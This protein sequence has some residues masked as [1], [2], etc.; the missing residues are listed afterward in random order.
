M[1]NLANKYR[2]RNFEDIVEQDLVVQ[3]VN[4]LCESDQ[5]TNRNFLF[6]GPAGTG[7]TTIS[8][9][10]ASELNEG[11][12]EV[13][14]ID[15]ASHGSIDNVRSI[16]EQAKKYPV[17]SK[18][19]VFIL[20]ECFPS[21]TW[22]DT[23]AGS[24]QIKDIH[25]GDRVYNLTGE[26]TVTRVFENTV[27]TCN[28]I[29]IRV[30]NRVIVT[31][32]DHL[33]FTDDGWVTA[34]N[35]KEGD[36]LYD[37]TCMQSLRNSVRSSVSERFTY[38]LQ[39]RVSEGSHATEDDRKTYECVSKNVSDMWKRF[40]DTQEC[41]CKNM[42]LGVWQ[43][44]EEAESQYGTIIGAT[45]KTLAYIYLS[46]MWENTR[47]S[48][49]RSSDSVFS[50]MCKPDNKS[51]SGS[52]CCSKYLPMVWKY[53]C[54]E[55]RGSTQEDMFSRMSICTDSES[56]CRQTISQELS[57]H[58]CEQSYEASRSCCKD[59]INEIQKRYLTQSACVAWWERTLHKAAD[60]APPSS[61]E[62][63]D[64]RVSREN[65]YKSQQQSDEISYELQTRPRL[66]RISDRCRGGW[67]RPS[68]EIASVVRREKSAVSSKLR[69]DSVE[70]YKRGYNDELFQG[71]FSDTELS[72]DF[73]TMYDLEVD[74]HPSYYANGVLV[75]NCHAFSNTSWQVFLKVLEES[76]AMTVMIF[77][78]TNPE[79][80]PA[81]IL[82]RVQTFKLSKISLEGVSSRLKYVLDS[83][84]AE[85][86]EIT[87]DEEAV[88]FVARLSNGGMRD[89]LT[90]LDKALAYCNEINMHNLETALNLPNYDNYFK[91]LQAYAKRDNSTT[92]A[93]IDDVYNSGINFIQWFEGF[94]SF[95]INVVKYILLGD[96]NRTLVPSHYE[97]RISKYSS[98]HLKICLDLSDNVLKLIHELK[99][100]QYLQEVAITYLCRSRKGDK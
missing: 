75:H 16:V 73:V 25:P 71:S 53:I 45:C 36:L 34:S 98:A 59:D 8:R 12:G 14:E 74:G 37:Q 17:G 4:N 27:K 54:S 26:A 82:S 83:E 78:T 21:N 100:T 96:I 48:Q 85:G 94:H 84:I 62:F 79:K 1:A 72:Q 19:K 61:G 28:L 31:T 47:N 56:S 60:S 91:L 89:A 67:C 2:P 35:L 38:D 86:Q 43:S 15:A 76:P 80:I 40:L 46:R 81:T 93:T 64:I 5:L 87:Y 23:P 33:F 99:S 65:G 77:C 24:V 55:L 10:I 22:I 20:D 95:V 49:Q 39:Q 29:S 13:I 50:E 32:K 3:I 92:V 68:Y 18:Y 69:V 42:F 88:N 9:I 52:T 97:D 7:K 63:V 70:I 58:D 11:V 90:T 6:T 51:E 44:L 30:G 41:E 57:L 66:S